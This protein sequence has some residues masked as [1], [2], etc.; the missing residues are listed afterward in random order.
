MTINKTSDFESNTDTL[1]K[2]SSNEKPNNQTKLPT[3]SG[4][5]LPPGQL[6]CNILK[7]MLI[8]SLRYRHFLYRK[9]N[10][11]FLSRLLYEI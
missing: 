5:P 4:V 11:R 3:T 7:G 8:E 9:K 1:K 2:L 6:K 10:P